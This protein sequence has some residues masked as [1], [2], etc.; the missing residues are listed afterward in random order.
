MVIKDENWIG[1]NLLIIVPS[2]FA[3]S[4]ALMNSKMASYEFQ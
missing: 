1:F 4:K 2:N 3:L